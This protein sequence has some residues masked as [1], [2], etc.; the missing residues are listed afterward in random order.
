MFLPKHWL[1]S[2]AVQLLQFSWLLALFFLF[3]TAVKMVTQY[4]HKAQSASTHRLTEKTK[5]NTLIMIWTNSRSMMKTNGYKSFINSRIH[6]FLSEFTKSFFY[7]FDKVQLSQTLSYWPIHC[8][9]RKWCQFAIQQ[10]RFHFRSL[11]P[12]Q[13]SLISKQRSSTTRTQLLRT[14]FTAAFT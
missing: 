7:E 2:S 3:F 12:L 14:H 13:W 4:L 6:A 1:E 8:P 5:Q 10:C 11:S 9:S